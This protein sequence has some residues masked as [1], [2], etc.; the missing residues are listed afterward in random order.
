MHS[1][2]QNSTIL[3]LG[4]SCGIDDLS[5]LL[6][7][8]SW[9]YLYVIYDTNYWLSETKINKKYY[10]TTVFFLMKII[11]CKCSQRTQEDAQLAQLTIYSVIIQECHK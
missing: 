5:E 2:Y 1:L 3:K 4:M 7:F 8:T 9:E 6:E 11:F 10:H